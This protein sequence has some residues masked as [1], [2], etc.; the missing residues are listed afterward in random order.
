[1]SGF[2]RAASPLDDLG[3]LVNDVERGLRD[4]TEVR[5]IDVVH[6]W[7][8][9]FSANAWCDLDAAGLFFS[10]ASRL[11]ILKLRV[12][13]PCPVEDEPLL[14]PAVDPALIGRLGE[15][16]ALLEERQH[17][18]A[19]CTLEPESAPRH[20]LIA[21]ADSLAALLQAAGEILQSLSSAP[22]HEVV[23][24]F[25]AAEE[26]RARVSALLSRGSQ[27]IHALLAAAESLLEAISYFLALL[28]II[29]LGWC[30]IRVEGSEVWLEPSLLRGGEA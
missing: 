21:D 5:L 27:R 1:M 13:L 22:P 12:L 18:H 6:E 26:A 11:L 14:L 9:A 28:E 19:L 30:T 3:V 24:E 7:V 2:V 29:R 23:G 10:L 15:R 20:R 25:L 17:S 4:P 8:G 16:L